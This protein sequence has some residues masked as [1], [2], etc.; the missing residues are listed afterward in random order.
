MKLI[1]LCCCLL[2]VLS[3]KDSKEK[4]YIDV[5]SQEKKPEQVH[6]G[7]KLMKVYCY[8]CH[9]AKTS[10]EKRVAPPMIAIKRRYMFG[11][12]SKNEFITDIQGFIAEPSLENAK[13]YGAVKRFGVMSKMI[14]PEKVISDIADYMYDNELEKPE[15][16]E[17]HYQERFKRRNN[18]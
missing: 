7:K 1:L 2:A 12:V 10:H 14:Y 18:N 3:C 17:E 16:F 15:W 11:D 5:T 4:Q 8:Q 13:M 9:D 6:R